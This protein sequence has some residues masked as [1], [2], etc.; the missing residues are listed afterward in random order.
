MDKTQVLVLVALFIGSHSSGQDKCLL[1]CANFCSAKMPCSVAVLVLYLGPGK[2]QGGASDHLT[3][4]HKHNLYSAT[5]QGQWLTDYSRH[6]HPRGHGLLLSCLQED[7][8]S[9]TVYRVDDEA[10]MICL[11]LTQGSVFRGCTE[12]LQH[13]GFTLLEQ[14]HGEEYY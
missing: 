8:L 3:S 4:L 2:A 14:G 5:G 9:I 7:P 1:T 11:E 12:T 6:L 13:D 10:I